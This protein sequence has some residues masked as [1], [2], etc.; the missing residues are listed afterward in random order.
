MEINTL[1]ETEWLDTEFN[2][3]PL[4]R[5]F[6]KRSQELQ[7]ELR[8]GEVLGIEKENFHRYLVI[9]IGGTLS[10]YTL[11][12]IEGSLFEAIYPAVF[13]LTADILADNNDNPLSIDTKCVSYIIGSLMIHLA[14]KDPLKALTLLEREYGVNSDDI[15][16]IRSHVTPMK[17][18]IH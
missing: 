12:K 6:L 17:Q 18:V 13:Y 5:G 11:T 14:P 9:T 16:W 2:E 8:L 1:V 4:L 15:A 3:D 7:E 10:T